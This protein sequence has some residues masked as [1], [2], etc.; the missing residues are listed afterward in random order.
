ML[1]LDTIPLQHGLTW[2]DK[3][4]KDKGK[5]PSPVFAEIYGHKKPSEFRVGGIVVWGND[6][7]K[8]TCVVVATGV[9]NTKQ[10]C[11]DIT[12]KEHGT[13]DVFQPLQVDLISYGIK[14]TP[15]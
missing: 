2:E 6:S 9:H 15:P 10:G 5:E 11:V 13:S 3:K 7:G 14:L 12:V 8:F 4:G 1:R